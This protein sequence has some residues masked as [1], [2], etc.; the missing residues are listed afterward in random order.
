MQSSRTINGTSVLVEW[1]EQPNFEMIT[2]DPKADT[3]SVQVPAG[4]YLWTL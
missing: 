2:S 4:M 3:E 1:K